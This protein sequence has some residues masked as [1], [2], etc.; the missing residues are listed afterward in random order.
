MENEKFPLAKIFTVTIS[1]LLLTA[2][3]GAF[4]GVSFSSV[5]IM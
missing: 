3:L 1:L 5:I 2:G 4:S